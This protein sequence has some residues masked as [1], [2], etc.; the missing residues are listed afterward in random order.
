MAITDEEK[1]MFDLEGY[2]GIKDVLTDDEVAELNG[3][4]DKKF[5]YAD[6]DPT[7]VGGRSHAEKISVWGEPF[8]RLIGHPKI[9]PYL[10]ELIEPKFRIDH[11]YCIFMSEGDTRGGLHGGPAQAAVDGWYSYRHGVIRNGLCVV[12][13]F[14][15]DAPEGAGG[16]ACIPGSHKTNFQNLVPDDVRRLDRVPN[17][18]VQPAV[19]AGDALF[20]TEALMHGTMPWRAKHERRAL[21]FKYSPG[22]SSWAEEYYDLSLYGELAD[23]QKRIMSPPSVG[24]RPDVVQED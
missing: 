5:P 3:I 20:F 10:V 19:E 17:Y 15:T 12:T 2:L 18:V 6:L 22:N 7:I 9:V 14:L 13:Y 21:L 23:Q 8:A 16:L 1:F 4:A 24:H 11:D